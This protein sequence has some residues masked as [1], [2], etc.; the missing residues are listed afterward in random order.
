MPF[1]FARGRHYFPKLIQIN[2]ST[3]FRM[4][5]LW[6]V[7][8]LVKILIFTAGCTVVQSAVL[9]S[10]VVCLSV[11]LS[12]CPSVCLSVRLSVTLV[13]CD[14]IVWNSS[15]L[16]SNLVTWDVRSLQPQHDV[17]ATRGTP[18]NLGPKWPTPCWLERRRHSI[19]NFGRMVTDSATVTME[20]L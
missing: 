18:L 6:F 12:V 17:S 13:D 3:L 7:P 8:D 5:W 15:K 19:A 10:H 2:Y 20:S 9:P 16:I 11:R 1:S 4:K 14:H